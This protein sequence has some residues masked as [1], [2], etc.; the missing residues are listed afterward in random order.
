MRK[1]KYVSWPEASNGQKGA[2]GQYGQISI[3]LDF[4]NDF[5]KCL[6]ALGTRYV[7]GTRKFA[8][9]DHLNEKTFMPSASG[10]KYL[11]F[12]LLDFRLISEPNLSIDIFSQC[13]SRILI[14]FWVVHQSSK[15]IVLEILSASLL[16]SHPN[17]KT[18]KCMLSS[19]VRLKM[20]KARLWICVS[21][22]PHFIIC[23]VTKLSVYQSIHLFSKC[24][25]GKSKENRIASNL[26]QVELNVFF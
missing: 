9:F 15:S 2:E 18:F 22:L 26:C 23:W 11:E 4:V 20:L 8:L 10:H 3:V 24:L 13:C 16:H 6:I 17:Q 12:N 5:R 1:G 25:T 7:G 21:L 19:K 14:K